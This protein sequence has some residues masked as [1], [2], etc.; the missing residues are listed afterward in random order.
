MESSKYYFKGSLILHGDKSISHRLLML[1]ALIRS[2]HILINL[3]KNDDVIATINSLKTFGLIHICEK[4]K[5]IFDTTNFMFKD[6]NIDCNESGTTARLM[7]GFLS[8]TGY[9]FTITGSKSLLTRPMDRVVKPLAQLGVNITSTNGK[10][11]VNIKHGSQN[12]SDIN[13]TINIASAQV[14]SAIILYAINSKRQCTIN[15]KIQSR[16]HTERLLNS[17]SENVSFNKNKIVI[18]SNASINH[19]TFNTK[20]PGDI[21]SASFLL[22]GAILMKDSNIIIN[23]IVINDYRIGFIKA[24]KVMGAN[25]ILS[26]KETRLGEDIGNISAIYSQNLKGITIEPD[27]VSSIIDEIPILCVVAA[28][29]KTRTVIKGVDE[30][31]YK[32][33][34]RVKAIIDNFKS[35]KGLARVE[36]DN[37]IIEPN[38]KLHNTTIISFNDH[39]IYMA[40]YIFN[41][42]LGNKIENEKSKKICDKSFP[43]FF[44]KINEITYER[45]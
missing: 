27:Q 11:P 33:S 23:D 15:G 36:N 42:V 28:F 3:P 13:Y 22:A 26:K 34:N 40:F 39:R 30:L 8:G 25:I 41:L 1:S 4:N 2:R 16:D 35:I 21:S 7:C 9:N 14:K 5:D 32:E 38:K 6:A 18:T 29:A 31:R 43:N 10:L 44:S 12:F 19:K 20:I 37:L 17:L 24:L 45:V